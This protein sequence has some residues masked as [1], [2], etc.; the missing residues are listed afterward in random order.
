MLVNSDRGC[1]FA[2]IRGDLRSWEDAVAAGG[3]M[4]VPERVG[5]GSPFIGA[6]FLFCGCGLDIV[7]TDRS[8]AGVFDLEIT[9]VGT[10]RG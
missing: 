5:V 6:G 2:A 8:L 10:L 7:L 4:I 3:G 1:W 9:A